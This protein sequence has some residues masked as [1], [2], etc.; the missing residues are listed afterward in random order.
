ML[1]GLNLTLYA[2]IIGQT[3]GLQ[4]IYIMTIADKVPWI[5]FLII[6]AL[7][8]ICIPMIMWVD[9]VEKPYT[10]TFDVSDSLCQS[11]LKRQRNRWMKSC[12]RRSRRSNMAHAL[13][14]T[15]RHRRIQSATTRSKESDSRIVS[16]CD[17]NHY[18]FSVIRTHKYTSAHF[19]SNRAQSAL[20]RHD[21]STSHGAHVIR[22]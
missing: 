21:W 14:R 12:K 3:W 7:N 22:R 1:L 17:T 2:A 19:N 16:L 5:M 4:Y 6:A 15:S 9:Y 13:T 11:Y 18:L 20:Q 10:R 8:F